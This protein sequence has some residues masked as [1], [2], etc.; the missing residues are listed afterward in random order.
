MATRTGFV[1]LLLLAVLMLAAQAATL[2]EFISPYLY[3]GENFTADITATQVDSGGEHF[4]MVQVGSAEAFFLKRAA[5]SENETVYMFVNDTNRIY[6]VLREYYNSTAYPSASELDEIKALTLA[7]NSTR[8]PREFDCKMGIGL[9]RPGATC[10]V[11]RCESCMSVPYCSDKMPYF[12]DDFPLSIHNFKV[13]SDAM[14]DGA[15]GAILAVDAL[16]NGTVDASLYLKYIAGN[17]TIIASHAGT[18]GSNHL[19]GCFALQGS[20]FPPMGLEWCAYRAG[21]REESQW[22]RELTLNK[23]YL[24]TA[25]GKTA[26]LQGRVVSDDTLN[27]RARAYY[28]AMNSR[29]NSLQFRNENATFAAFFEFAAERADSVSTKASAALGRVSDDEVSTDMAALSNL[30]LTLTQYGE[31]RNYTAANATAAQLYVLA[32]K[33]EAESD[34][35]NSAYDGI[36]RLNDTTALAIFRAKL[37][38]EPQDRQLAATLAGYDSESREV[39]EVISSGVPLTMQEIAEFGSDLNFISQ[40]S[41][42]VISE[43]ESQ[44]GRQAGTLITEVARVVSEAFINAFSAVVSLSPENKEAYARTLPTLVVFLGGAFI[45]FGCVALFAMFVL[46]KKLRLHRVAVLLWAFIFAFLFVLVGIGVVTTNTVIQQQASRSMFGLFSSQIASSGGAA[47]V[48]VGDGTDAAQLAALQDCAG[49]LGSNLTALGKDVRRYTF[50]GGDCQPA[51]G[52][53]TTVSECQARLG[54][55]PLF[56]L[57]YANETQATFYVY[58]IKEAQLYGNGTFYSPCYMARVFNAN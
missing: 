8:N 34:T 29:A 36:I 37:Y 57:H 21:A 31:A 18:I 25:S 55:D 54:T 45:Y 9:D 32:D 35:L 38:L 17:L 52:S 58:Y 44:R 14:D 49:A 39:A 27:A 20:A 10:A 1:S 6:S 56:M 12:G 43:K 26:L 13:D 23:T 48:V 42:S 53:A 47:I 50:T 41:R 11:D 16:R 30:M 5:S 46:S 22:C 51:N 40:R 28:T 3:P 15:K 2:Q 7:F 24:T 19:F 4:V 33:I